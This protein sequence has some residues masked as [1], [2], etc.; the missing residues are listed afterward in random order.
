MNFLSFSYL[1]V[2]TDM[3]YEA[4]AFN[5]DIGSWDVSKGVK[6]VSTAT[7]ISITDYYCINRNML[8]MNYYLIF[9]SHCTE[10]H[11]QRCN[12]IQPGHCQLGCIQG[13]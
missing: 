4:N 5:Q 9:L 12:R 11:V 3:F 1:I 7:S 10:S 8:L 6:F 2:Q 13:C